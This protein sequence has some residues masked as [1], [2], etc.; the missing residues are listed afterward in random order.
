M[1]PLCPCP[2]SKKPTYLMMDKGSES[3]AIHPFKVSHMAVSGDIDLHTGA[4]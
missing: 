3:S 1:G 4:D 2:N